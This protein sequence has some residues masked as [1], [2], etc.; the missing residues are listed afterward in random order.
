MSKD[1]LPVIIRKYPEGDLIAF[2]PMVASSRDTCLSYQ[3][4]GQHGGATPSVEG[5]NPATP[6]EQAEMIE[7]L[8]KVMGYEHLKLVHKFTRKH[9][10]YRNTQC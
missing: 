7:H 4:I 1:S 3:I 2:F 10:E 8:T 5:T 9:A 6:E